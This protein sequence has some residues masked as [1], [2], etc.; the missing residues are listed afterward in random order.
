[1][2]ATSDSERAEISSTVSARAGAALTAAASKLA[3]AIREGVE[4]FRQGPDEDLPALR[5]A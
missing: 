3:G 2:M 4:A 5:T 1:M